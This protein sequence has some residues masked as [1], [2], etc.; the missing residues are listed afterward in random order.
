MLKPFRWG[1]IVNLDLQ[2]RGGASGQPG[3][4]DVIVP[5]V[6]VGLRAAGPEPC[7]PRRV[8]PVVDLALGDALGPP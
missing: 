8:Q 4:A 1:P 5:T 7:L 6:G 2:A 3:C